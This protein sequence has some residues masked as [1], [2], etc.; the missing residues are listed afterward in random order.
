MSHSNMGS[1]DIMYN[2]YMGNIGSLCR[3]NI[4]GRIF[5]QGLSEG[6]GSGIHGLIGHSM[7]GITLF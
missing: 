7:R 3:D 4:S 1:G 5:F 2:I 6:I